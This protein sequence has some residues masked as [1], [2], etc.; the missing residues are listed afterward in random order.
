MRCVAREFLMSEV[1]FDLFD[2]A[3][4]SLNE[5]LEK[6]EEGKAGDEKAFKFCVKHLSHFLELI[7]KYYVTQSHPLLIYKNPFAKLINEESQTI[8]LYEAINFLKNEG[9]DISAKFEKDISWLKKLRNSMEHHKFSMNVREVEETVGRLMSA[10]VEFDDLH[11]SV[12]LSIHISANQYELFHDLANVYENRL[13]RAELEVERVMSKL[14]PKEDNLKVHH[15]YECDHD[16][17]VPSQESSTGYKCIF[18]G[19]EESEDILAN[20]EICGSS[21]PNGDMQLIDWSDDG[22]YQYYCPYCLHGPE[23][24]SD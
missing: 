12:N 5:A 13:K 14:D 7:L 20:C 15:C 10:V 4:D 16:T 24:R 21:W 17:L 22:S 8:G 3:I 1:E 18:C 9:C 6:F 19:N 11:K 23:Y 2:N